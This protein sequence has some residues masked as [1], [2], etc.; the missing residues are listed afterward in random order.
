M[1]RVFDELPRLSLEEFL[2]FD[3]GTD[4]RY[5]LRDGWLH[6][7]NPP[8]PG[9]NIITTNIVKIW[10]R[11]SPDLERCRSIVTPGL[12]INVARDDYYIPDVAYTCEQL[13]DARYIK[14]PVI[15]AEVLSPSTERDDM[16]TKLP[17]YASVPSIMEIWLV[18]SRERWVRVHS[19]QGDSWTVG[20]PAV[21]S[22]NV[23]S[24]FLDGPV[25]LDDIYRGSG[26]PADMP[27]RGHQLRPD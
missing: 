17:L 22:G 6:A 3:D 20:L 7:M 24:R 25:L 10:D 1:A 13:A 21:G 18:G 19:R 27:A 11:V 4:T 8:R 9:H 23:E 16:R 12:V 26:V 2:R 14:E 5:E 15:V